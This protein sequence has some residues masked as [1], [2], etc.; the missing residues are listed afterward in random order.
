MRSAVFLSACGTINMMK[1][2][3]RKSACMVLAVVTALFC[4]RPV[5]AETVINCWDETKK[6]HYQRRKISTAIN[7]YARKGTVP[8]VQHETGVLRGVEYDILRVDPS[9]NTFLKVDYSETPVY[10]SQLEDRKLLKEG[11]V[12]VG[13]INAGYFNNTNTQY[14]RPV[15]AVRMNNQWTTW[16]GSLNTPAYGSGYATAYFNRYDME[17]RYHGWQKG[18]WK[19][20]HNWSYMTGYLIDAENAVSGSYT[21]FA[22]GKEQDITGGQV[23]GINYHT[24]GRALTIFAQKQTGQFLLIEFYG[25]IPDAAVMELL[26]K[27]DVRDAI[28]LDGGGSCQM[29]YDDTLVNQNYSPLKQLPEDSPKFSKDAVTAKRERGFLSG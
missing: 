28:R 22:D 14:G 1:C 16:H 15:G 13:G 7:I 3:L 21:Y 6:A 29:I 10:L 24:Y 9:R 11:Y 12:R 25:T 5:L 17:I 19:G 26:R 8:F 2:L 20:D 18:T 27:E 4:V 23:G